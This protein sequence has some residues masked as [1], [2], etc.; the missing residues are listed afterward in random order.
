M[1]I[2]RLGTG[3]RM[4]QAVVHG[5]MV[6]LSGQVGE[7]AS[8]ADE[9]RDCLAKVDHWLAEAGTDKSHIL[10][11]TV[12]LS[13]MDYFAEMN[14]VYDAWIDPANPPARAAGEARLATPDFH[15]EFIV[16]AVKP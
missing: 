6:Y 7:G 2:E 11:V 9:T 16:V 4:S 8:I 14:S 1:S 13:S 10:S 5:N 12:W 15:V 3:P